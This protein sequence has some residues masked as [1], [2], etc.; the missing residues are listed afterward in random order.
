MPEDPGGKVSGLTIPEEATPLWI[1]REKRLNLVSFGL[2]LLVVLVAMLG[3]VGVRTSTAS[4]ISPD[5]E[6]EVLHSSITRPGLATPFA[7]TI[8]SREGSLPES[9]TVRV[10]SGYLD[11][12]DEHGL[13]PS[14]ARSH[15]NA[16]WTWW[17][18][19][20]PGGSE[21]LT[22]TLDARLEPSVQWWR[23]G[24]VAVMVAEEV[25]A[26]VYVETWVLP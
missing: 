12:F 18:F 16:D 10:D 13:T 25:Q 8:R 11:I 26:E 2:V 22:V 9:V 3:L 19:Q 1:R 14:P 24:T 4:D 17:T 20:L 6:L 21:E 23:S 5:V 7:V 15:S